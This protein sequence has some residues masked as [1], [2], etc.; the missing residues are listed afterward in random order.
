MTIVDAKYQ[1][2]WASSRYPGNSHDAMI[3][4]STNLFHKMKNESLIPSYY[5]E[6]DGV[7]IYPT[8][9]GDSAFPF[10]PWLMKPYGSTT[11]TEQQRYFNY[12]LSRARMVVE[13]AFGQLKGRWRILQRKNE[14]DVA[15]V[16]IMS[17][18][19]IILHNVCIEM[20]DDCPTAW[21]IACDVNK[22]QRR[23]RSDVCDLLH[24]TK[25]RKIPDSSGKAQEVRDH[26][27]NKL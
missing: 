13:G 6:D 3:L 2:M 7:E 8:L 22:T 9:V 27:K 16:K 1:F 17:L 4:Q 26:L 21:N 15:T 20:D 12:R 25:C 10:L 5:K 11:L 19:C 23:P 14:S 18:A 24:M